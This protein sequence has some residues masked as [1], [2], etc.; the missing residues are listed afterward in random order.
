M[1][2]ENICSQ[3]DFIRIPI[4]KRI[5]KIIIT[6]INLMNKHKDF[7]KRT[8]YFL[9]IPMNYKLLTAYLYKTCLI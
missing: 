2:L 7:Y 3:Y 5:K 6:K 9:L 1:K 8:F 4:H